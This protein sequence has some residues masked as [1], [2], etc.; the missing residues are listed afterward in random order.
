[1]FVV[2][3]GPESLVLVLLTTLCTSCH[4][5]TFLGSGNNLTVLD[6]YCKNATFVLN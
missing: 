3:A 1:M 5:N 2:Q 4:T 6:S